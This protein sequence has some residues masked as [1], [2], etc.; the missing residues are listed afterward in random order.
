MLWAL[1]VEAGECMLV[2]AIPKPA[3]AGLVGKG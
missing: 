3:T 1:T 2:T